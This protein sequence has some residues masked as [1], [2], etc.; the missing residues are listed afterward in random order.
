VQYAIDIARRHS[1]DARVRRARA[2]VD[3]L[4]NALDDHRGQE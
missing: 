4:L 2:F 3:A 1:A